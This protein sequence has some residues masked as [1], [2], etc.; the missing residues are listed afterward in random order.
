M[1]IYIYITM[2]ICFYCICT[3]YGHTH[4]VYLLS[5]IYLFTFMFFWVAEFAEE[6]VGE[7][8]REKQIV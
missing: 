6:C 5:L 4:L 2:Y 1:Y 8:I 7:V 3:N